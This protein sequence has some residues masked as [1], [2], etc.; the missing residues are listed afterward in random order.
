MALPRGHYLVAPD[1]QPG[2]PAVCG[3]GA[4][5][6]GLALPPDDRVLRLAHAADHSRAGGQPQDQLPSRGVGSPASVWSAP[7]P[8]PLRSLE[9]EGMSGVA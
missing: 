2:R 8:K 4:T 3:V 6:C 9:N 1:R 7:T 5:G